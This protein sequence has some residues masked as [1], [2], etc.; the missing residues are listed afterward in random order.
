MDNTWEEWDRQ[1]MIEMLVEER[2]VHK[3]SIGSH[4]DPINLPDIMLPGGDTNSEVPPE[5]DEDEDAE[6]TWNQHRDS[7][8][9]GYDATNNSKLPRWERVKNKRVNWMLGQLKRIGVRVP[10]EYTRANGKL[11]IVMEGVVSGH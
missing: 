3:H 1:D 10:A 11:E 9:T 4:E 6:R 7:M 5:P 2:D 8:P